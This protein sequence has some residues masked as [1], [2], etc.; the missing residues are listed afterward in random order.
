MRRAFATRIAN[1]AWRTEGLFGEGDGKSI[2][3]TNCNSNPS[4]VVLHYA[5]TEAMQ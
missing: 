3:L 4:H 5:F 1:N 2:S